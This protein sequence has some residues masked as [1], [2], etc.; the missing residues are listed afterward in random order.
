MALVPEVYA[1]AGRTGRGLAVLRKAFYLAGHT[2]E[3]WWLA[4][5]HRLRGELL[6]NAGRPGE[7]ARSAFA[8]AVEVA[9]RQGALLPERLAAEGLARLS[10]NGTRQAPKE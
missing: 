4:E 3:E 9:R 10:H 5:L 7:E 6:M 2:G 1:K 8:D